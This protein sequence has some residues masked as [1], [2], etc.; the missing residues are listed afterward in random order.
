MP[1]VRRDLGREMHRSSRGSRRKARAS[2]AA[3][4]Q[5][6]PLQ[7]FGDGR[8]RRRNDR[9]AVGP[10]LAVEVVV[11]FLVAAL[12]GDGGELLGL[13]LRRLLLRGQGARQRVDDVFHCPVDTRVDVGLDGGLAC[14]GRG[15][16]PQ[17]GHA[18][19]GRRGVGV[20]YETAI[21]Q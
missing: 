16:D 7:H 21:R 3:G 13:D 9:H 18:L 11:D 5:V 10:A 15:Q 8:F 6:G 12:E 20:I 2:D 1:H 14:D 19:S 4:R 17:A